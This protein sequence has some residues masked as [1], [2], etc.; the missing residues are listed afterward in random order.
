MLSKAVPLALDAFVP[1]LPTGNVPVT[2]EVEARLIVP[3][4]GFAE[5]PCEISACPDVAPGPT[6]AIALVPLPSSTAYCVSVLSPVPPFATPRT[7]E[8]DPLVCNDSQPPFTNASSAG[9][10]SP[11]LY[12]IIPFTPTVGRVPVVP[13]G[14]ATELFDTNVLLLRSSAAPAAG[15]V[16]PIPT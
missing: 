4:I 6:D 5:P 13:T 3:K 15:D 2:I 8:V 12:R 1:P 16:V 10:V 11:V 9:G 7:P 14:N